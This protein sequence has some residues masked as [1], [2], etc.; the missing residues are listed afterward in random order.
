MNTEEIIEISEANEPQN[1][2]NLLNNTKKVI[3]SVKGNGGETIVNEIKEVKD[4]I[5]DEIKD[6]SNNENLKEKIKEIPQNMNSEEIIN[7]IRENN[8]NESKKDSLLTG[9]CKSCQCILF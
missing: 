9:P 1:D 5:K 4:E 6:L 7:E 3:Q 2:N 8:V